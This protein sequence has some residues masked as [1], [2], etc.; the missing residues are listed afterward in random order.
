MQLITRPSG[1]A[2]FTLV[3]LAVVL[4]VFGIVV[5]RGIPAISDYTANSAI[6]RGASDLHYAANLA[7]SEAV[8]RNIRTEL[9]ITPSSWAV[10]NMSVTPAVQLQGAGLDP[11]ARASNAT[12]GF[13]SNGR[14]FP[15]GM[16]AAIDMTRYGA[17]C[18]STIRCLSVRV[19]C[20]GAP[21][22]CEPTKSAGSYG[23]C[24]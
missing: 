19:S 6:R 4:T 2:G 10:F 17:T 24:P 1:Q 3:E 16:Q 8:K 7:R 21:S 13:A 12:V 23:A 5:A 20:G 11:A 9:R 18:S 14:T 22:I 15:A